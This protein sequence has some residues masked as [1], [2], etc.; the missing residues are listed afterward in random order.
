MRHKKHSNHSNNGGGRHRSR[1]KFRGSH[2]GNDS[3]SLA[4]Q[5]KHAQTQKEKYLQQARDAQQNG[6]RVDAEY[7]YQHVEHFSRVLS[8]I[9][10]KET[11]ET[12][13][14]DTQ[15]AASDANDADLAQEGNQ[16]STLSESQTETQAELSAEEKKP[17]RGRGRRTTATKESD[18]AAGN[19]EEKQAKRA[20]SRGRRKKTDNDGDAKESEIPLPSSVIP[21]AENNEQAVN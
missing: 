1:G 13:A 7:Y 18:V 20:T 8:D 6:E 19:D 4:R 21:Q 15:D 12:Q 17:A 10:E 5:K 3:Q 14:D 2:G 16:Q 11:P 9:A